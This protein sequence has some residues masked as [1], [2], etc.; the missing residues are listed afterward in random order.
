M[1]RRLLLTLFSTVSSGAYALLRDAFTDTANPMVDGAAQPGAG[2]RDVTGTRW[3]TTLGKLFGGSAVGEGSWGNSKVIYTGGLARLNG[4]TLWA[5]IRP[6]DRQSPLAFSWATATNITDPR[7]DGHGW[8]MLDGSL[9]II[10]PSLSVLIDVSIHDM[11]PM[12]YLIAHVLFDQGAA[13]LISTVSTDGTTSP[14]RTTPWSVPAYPSASI[15]YVTWRGTTTPLYPSI[16]AKDSPNTG[17]AINGHTF[18][19]VRVIDVAS[20]S[21]LDSLATFADRF[22]RADN[23]TTPS[24]S[25]INDRGTWGILSNTLYIAVQPGAQ[26]ANCRREIGMSDGTYHWTINV[27][28]TVG[29]FAVTFRHVSVGNFIRF[30]NNGTTNAWH[31]QIYA[32]GAFSSSIASGPTVWAINTTYE[33]TIKMIGNK[34]FITKDDVVL[35]TNWVADATSTYLAGTGI[36]VGTFDAVGVSPTFD[37]VAAYPLTVTLPSELQQTQSLAI[38]QRTAGATLGSDTF[39]DTNGTLLTAHT[40]TAGPLWS[41]PLAGSNATIQSNRLSLG[42]AGAQLALQSIATAYHECQVDIILPGSLGNFTF[43]GICVAY[44]DVDNWFVARLAADYVN[45]PNEHE[46]EVVRSLAAVVTIVG[47]VQFGVYFVAGN[48]VALKIQIVSD[49]KGSNVVLIY[50]DGN[51]VESYYLPAALNGST[52]AGIYR[53]ATTDS[54]AVFDNWSVKAL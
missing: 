26:M 38:F 48:T 44:I 54:G 11:R 13:L 14:G 7:T 2:T 32:A 39:T 16:S 33:I 28:G 41:V 47:K 35:T 25:W 42:G 52:G 4:R 15:A 5:V 45:Q 18:D 27:L 22:T 12:L 29:Q 40:P 19:D 49:G 9:D 37:N 50:L 43:A 24:N 8:Y 34:Y 23:A 6:E 10:T 30:S 17:E 36:G 20:W 53:D 1:M 46:I 3:F 21:A 51:Y 31:L